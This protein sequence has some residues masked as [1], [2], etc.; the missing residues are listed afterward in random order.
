[1]SVTFITKLMDKKI[2]MVQGFDKVMFEVFLLRVYYLNDLEDVDC[3][4]CLF[5]LMQSRNSE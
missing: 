4:I 1:M 5:I 2:R 3:K